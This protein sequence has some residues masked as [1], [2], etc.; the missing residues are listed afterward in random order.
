MIHKYLLLF[1]L[2]SSIMS[3]RE[4]LGRD[5]NTRRVPATIE[6]GVSRRRPSP[7]KPVIIQTLPDDLDKILD[8]LDRAGPGGS[9][10]TYTGAIVRNS[11][12]HSFLLIFIFREVLVPMTMVVLQ[13][14]PAS[15]NSNVVH[16]LKSDGSKFVTSI[17]VQILMFLHK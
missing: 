3:I 1:M 7:R 8:S 5:D 12:N 6:A 11:G 17:I 15:L 2:I 9:D 16:F 14:I 4:F 10:T 13:H